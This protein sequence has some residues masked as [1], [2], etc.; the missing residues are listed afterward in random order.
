M[1]KS[2]VIAI[3]AGLTH[4]VVCLDTVVYTFGSMS[5]RGQMGHDS[6][7]GIHVPMAVGSLEGQKVVG[8]SAG[9]QHTA[10]WTDDGALYTFGCE[11]WGKLGHSND[12]QGV[13]CQP[14]VVEALVGKRV[15]G[16]AAGDSHTVAWTDRGEVYTFG[17]GV[18]LGHSEEFE[19]NDELAPVVVGALLGKS[20]A[21]A[22]TSSH[23]VAYTQAG[24]VFTFGPGIPR[25]VELAA[26]KVVGVAA[27]SVHTV[28]WTDRGD[29]Y[30]FGRGSS[31][32][33]G[34]GT[35][36]NENAPRMV[37]ALT[38]KNVVGAAAGVHHTVVWAERGEVYTFGHGY[39]GQ[40][41]HGTKDDEL[42][43][44]MVQA[45]VGQ[46]VIDAAASHCTV[47]VSIDGCVFTFGYGRGG[48]LGHG[49]DECEL[50]PRV[51]EI[52]QT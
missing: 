14:R 13:V 23:T 52:L 29:V 38:G 10:V 31:G 4:T 39:S 3:S 44:R 43:P 22:A 16:A 1:L 48:Q 26:E 28:L 11:L 42:T 12:G 20:V 37:Q 7:K 41:G 46:K 9:D 6:I 17:H 21:G 27:G 2:P 5:R 18:R 49:I 8:A 24:Q 50:L 19:P 25:A 32:R 36:E 34:H 30:T 15:M 47:V 33:L 51:V 45:L 40:L 35:Q